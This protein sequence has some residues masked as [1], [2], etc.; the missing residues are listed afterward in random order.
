MILVI[1]PGRCAG[2]YYRRPN[3]DATCIKCGTNRVSTL[4]ATECTVCEAGTVSNEDNTE[5]G[6]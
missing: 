4:G 3:I 2:G 6:E 5:C 1:L